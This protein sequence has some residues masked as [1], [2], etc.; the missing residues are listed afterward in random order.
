MQDSTTT[1]AL[2]T[3]EKNR[4]SAT[5][6]I[7]TRE[8]AL[9]T[10]QDL[11]KLIQTAHL[12][13]DDGVFDVTEYSIQDDGDVLWS[14][15]EKD[16]C[17]R[18]HIWSVNTSMWLAILSVHRDYL[19]ETSQH[20]QS[21]AIIDEFVKDA[22]YAK[23][24]EVC[25]TKGYTASQATFIQRLQ[26]VYDEHAEELKRIIKDVSQWDYNKAVQTALDICSN[27][28]KIGRM[29]ALLSWMAEYVEQ[30]NKREHCTVI[31]QTCALA[32]VAK[33]ESI[34]LSLENADL[35]KKISEGRN[36]LQDSIGNV[37][38]MRQINAE[39]SEKIKLF[40]LNE[41][42]ISH[43]VLCEPLTNTVIMRVL[44]A[45]AD[46]RKETL[47]KAPE[48]IEEYLERQAH[49]C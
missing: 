12:L 41:E 39:L 1:N 19:Q 8:T 36:A 21:E 17:E 42:A 27:D 22:V 30:A 48:G 28:T 26:V 25:E 14:I 34:N 43:L 47:P 20:N 33:M 37:E 38:E 18:V 16:F 6:T 9:Q 10:G 2:E 46:N 44:T 3:L 11:E 49:L 32:V 13:I 45:C 23:A 35:S 40:E 5:L 24:R 7:S 15:A 4:K 31:K 29:D